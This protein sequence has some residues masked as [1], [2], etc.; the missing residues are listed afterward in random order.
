MGEHLLSF[1]QLGGGSPNC[2]PPPPVRPQFPHGVSKAA[3]G[4][5]DLGDHHSGCGGESWTVYEERRSYCTI[6]SLPSILTQRQRGQQ[7]QAPAT[8]TA[9][10][11]DYTSNCEAKET[12]L[13]F[14][15]LLSDYFIITGK[16]AVTSDPCLKDLLKNLC[17]LGF[18][19]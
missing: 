2:V 8:S 12:H 4:E 9:T 19:G 15:C 6:P 11:M 5:S 16:V 1:W 3:F 18:S 13:S 14:K 7:L 17:C 10:M